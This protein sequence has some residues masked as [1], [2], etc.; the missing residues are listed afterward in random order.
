MALTLQPVIPSMQDARPDPADRT[1]QDARPDPADRKLL[2]L[3]VLLLF[4]LLTKP[5][6]LHH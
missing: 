2:I 1:M 4:N 6:K 5:D 3:K